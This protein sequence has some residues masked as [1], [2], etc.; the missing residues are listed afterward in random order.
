MSPRP[1]IEDLLREL[2]PQV[3]GTIIRRFGGLDAAEDAVQEALLA[4]AGHWPADGMPDNPRGWLIQAAT[5]RMTDQ[6]RSDQARRRREAI[7][8]AAEPPP[9]ND[10]A[11]AGDDTLILLF[12]CCHPVAASALNCIAGNCPARRS[13]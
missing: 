3:L 11:A 6:I 8:A 7:A 4:A 13:A 12:M 9:A 10:D 1:D 5:R 2:A